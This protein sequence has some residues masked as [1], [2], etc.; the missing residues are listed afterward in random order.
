MFGIG[1]GPSG[2]EKKEF[3]KLSGLADFATSHG[4]G[5]ISASDNFWKSILSG[6]PSKISQVLG[7]EIS[8][9]NNR[10]QQKKKTANEFG[11]RGG[12]TNAGNQMADDETRGE[13]DKMMSSLTSSA[14]GI[15]GS[16]GSNLLGQGV[17][18]HEGAFQES[19]I[20]H[21]QNQSKWDDLFKSI[22]QI[23]SSFGGGGVSGAIGDIG[24]SL[25]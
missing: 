10:A 1:H 15:L 8:G 19:N 25:S 6:D 9:I 14:A 5:D 4:E 3:G 20:I 13:I 11:D 12:G 18:A 23:A 17:G 21:D 2:D 7:P 22:A 16:Q 24:T